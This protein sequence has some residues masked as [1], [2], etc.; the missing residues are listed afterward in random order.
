M[1]QALSHLPLTQFINFRLILPC[2]V[3]HI[4]TIGLTRV[5]TAVYVHIEV[6]GL[7]PIE[8]TLSQ[9]LENTSGTEVVTYI[10]IRPWHSS[11]LDASVMTDNDSACQWLMR[12]QQPFSAL[13]LKELPQNEYKRVASSCYIRAH[14][15]NPTGVLK[16][17][18]TTLTMV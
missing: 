6:I 17:E 5:D 10:L 16:G 3:H 13:L 11:F 2:I 9:P 15:S 7:E 1:H 18:V 8:I 12:M 14:P 4:N